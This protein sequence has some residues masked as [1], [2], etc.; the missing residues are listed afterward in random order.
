MAVHAKEPACKRAHPASWPAISGSEP[1]LTLAF[2]SRSPPPLLQPLPIPQ[3][4]P[5][6]MS[7]TMG[8][9]LSGSRSPSQRTSA[10]CF[11]HT[12]SPAAAT[13]IQASP[14]SRNLRLPVFKARR[15][16]CKHAVWPPPQTRPLNFNQ[17][18]GQQRHNLNFQPCLVTALAWYASHKRRV[19]NNSS[20]S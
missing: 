7:T 1:L 15:D 5:S 8:R 10:T 2:C 6:S 19:T 18:L 4:G 3:P 12:C 17:E 20:L 14:A 13:E 16:R 11:T 9:G